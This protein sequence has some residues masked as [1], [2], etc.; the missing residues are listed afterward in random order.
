MVASRAETKK[1]PRVHGYVKFFDLFPSPTS[2]R[3][4]PKA[5]DVA[6]VVK[7]RWM[8]VAERELL[9]LVEWCSLD[10]YA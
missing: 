4:G 1:V 9:K 8:N 2:S 5:R 7:S 3:G 6:K 10:G